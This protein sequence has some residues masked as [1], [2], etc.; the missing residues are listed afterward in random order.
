[1][2]LCIC[3]PIKPLQSTVRHFHMTITLYN[4][5]DQG[6]TQ[7]QNDRNNSWNTNLH[8]PIKQLTFIG[9]IRYLW[10]R[11]SHGTKVHSLNYSYNWIS[12]AWSCHTVFAQLCRCIVHFFP[13][14]I[15]QVWILLRCLFFK[16]MSNVLINKVAQ[17]HCLSWRVTLR[18]FLSK[19]TNWDSCFL[20]YFTAIS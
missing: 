5:K 7:T 17:K 20:L 18:Y 19:S 14:R 9:I 4:K 16:L 10:V 12:V 15:D 13:N 3:P 1:M 8:I 2:Q 11:L 6:E